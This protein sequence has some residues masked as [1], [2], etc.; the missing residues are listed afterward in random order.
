MVKF[1]GR[2]HERKG[3]FLLAPNSFYALCADFCSLVFSGAFYTFRR[4]RAE[5]PFGGFFFRAEKRKHR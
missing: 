3:E 5:R 4:F 2:K 1:E